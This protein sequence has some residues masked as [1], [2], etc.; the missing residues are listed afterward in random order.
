MTV[1]PAAAAMNAASLAS[2]A[3]KGFLEEEQKMAKLRM[4]QVQ[5]LSGHA[6]NGESIKSGKAS[7]ALKAAPSGFAPQIAQHL[8]AVS[9]AAADAQRAANKALGRDM[10][11]GTP[12]VWSTKPA[13]GT[14]WASPDLELPSR[15]T[16]N[17]LALDYF[18]LG[19]LPA[20][21]AVRFAQ[22]EVA[23]ALQKPTPAVPSLQIVDEKAKK[24]FEQGTDI[25][26]SR[27]QKA[28]IL[29][30]PINKGWKYSLKKVQEK[31]GETAAVAQ[32]ATAISQPLS[33]G[34]GD[35]K[36]PAAPASAVG[37]Q[38][39]AKAVK[40]APK[41]TAKS[42][43]DPKKPPGF[44]SVG[45]KD[46]LDRLGSLEAEVDKLKKEKTL[47]DKLKILKVQQAKLEEKYPQLQRRVSTTVKTAKA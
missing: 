11:N 22:R 9:G 13:K 4:L 26:V 43:T 6:H 14:Y 25:V 34:K 10:S 32:G 37:V 28:G 38:P 21:T 24:A 1:D 17:G 30:M 36:A 45:S 8:Q 7:G 18:H 35:R 41:V 39:Q 31:T 12:V 15:T 47:E 29:P 27:R 33:A 40:L 16:R 46:V 2:V 19:S 42:K 44:A 23:G 3:E 5:Q 20:A